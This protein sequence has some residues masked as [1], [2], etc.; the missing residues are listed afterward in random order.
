MTPVPIIVARDVSI[1]WS[2]E[3]VL[4]ENASF[5]VPR[6]DVF[7]V[8][9]GSGTGKSTLMR[10]LIGLSE[11][12]SGEILVDGA[13]PII[14]GERPRYGVMFQDGALL[15]SMS[16]IDNVAAPLSEWVELPQDATRA[17]ARSLLRLVALDAAA[18]LYP[19]ELSGGMLK[20]AAIARA[21]ALE[22]PLIFLDE[23]SSGLDPILS[24]E[25]DDLIRTLKLRAHV[26]IVM[27]THD[28]G[29]VFATADRCILLDKGSRA[30]IGRGTPTDL[31]A[32]DD[33]RVR[34]FF[35]ARTEVSS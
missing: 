20:R 12:L 26:S 16:V 3:K 28:L 35:H 33:L 23:P 11:P 2:K 22:P 10:C 15:G 8:L 7:A 1:G 32:S 6:G 29:S 31:A 5:E 14:D 19:S 21:L 4:L 17:I 30:I 13:P 27:V 18:E 25:L 24:A 34:R 9:G